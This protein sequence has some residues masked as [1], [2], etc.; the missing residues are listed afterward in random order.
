MATVGQILKEAREAKFYTL[1]EVE[2]TT[3]IQKAMLKALEEDDYSKLP[4]PTFVQGFIKN[5]ARFLNLEPQKLLA[6]FRREFTRDR[7]KSGSEVMESFTKAVGDRK[8]IITPT[9]LVGLV[10]G[11]IILSFFVYLWLQ[12][13][14]FVGPPPLNLIS[15]TDQTTV[16]NPVITVE[17]TTDPEI[18]VLINAQIVPIDKDGHFKEDIALT[19][20]MNKITIVATSRFGQKNEIE[21]TV[22]LKR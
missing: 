11:L 9:K 6:I 20:Q 21:R 10:I 8:N 16:D 18:K 14:Q 2:K 7:Q 12:Y 3:K 19:T 13:R 22:Y 1:E 17:G 5:Y 15:P 4:P